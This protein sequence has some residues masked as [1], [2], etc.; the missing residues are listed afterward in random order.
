MLPGRRQQRHLSAATLPAKSPSSMRP[1]RSTSALSPRNI[2][3]SSTTSIMM[4]PSR[5]APCRCGR[6][7]SARAVERRRLA[8][9][10]MRVR[11]DGCRAKRR[12]SEPLLSSVT[13]SRR[14]SRSWPSSLDGRKDHG[15]GIGRGSLWLPSQWSPWMWVFEYA[16]TG[17]LLCF[18]AIFFSTSSYSTDRHDHQWRRRLSPTGSPATA[19]AFGTYQRV[20]RSDRF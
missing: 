10:D 17:S 1:M 5:C 13:S 19:S 11:R 12:R 14:R 15:L 16:L 18:A 9:F 7:E 8:V 6:C 3:F 4:S 2:S 20:P